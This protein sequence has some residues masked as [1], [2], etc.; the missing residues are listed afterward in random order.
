MSHIA[1][2]FPEKEEDKIYKRT[3][4]NSMRIT[5]E[6]KGSATIKLKDRNLFEIV[7]AS[8]KQPEELSGL[9]TSMEKA[10]KVLRAY[11]DEKHLTIKDV[12]RHILK[13]DN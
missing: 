8:M 6:P 12:D 13:H 10:Q 3:S 9:F 2:Y 4:L 11:I 5:F 7:F 1:N